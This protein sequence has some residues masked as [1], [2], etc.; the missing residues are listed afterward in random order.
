[1]NT[2]LYFNCDTWMCFLFT[3]TLTLINTLFAVIKQRLQLCICKQF[4]ISCTGVIQWFP[5]LTL[6]WEIS[7]TYFSIYSRAVNNF[8]V[9]LI[10]AT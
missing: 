2:Y 1:M 4:S 9:G 6:L 7:N 10:S 5:S 3:C 8:D